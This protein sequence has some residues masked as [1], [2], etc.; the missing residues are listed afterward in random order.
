M[1]QEQFLGIN[2]KIS[3]EGSSLHAQMLGI[4]YSEQN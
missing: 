2:R 4:D 1:W 3:L